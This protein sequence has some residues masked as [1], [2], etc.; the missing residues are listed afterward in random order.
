MS[1][2]WPTELRVSKDRQHLVV[3]FND[4]RSFDLS[5]EMLRVL[6]PSAEV[7][8]HGPGQKVTV[9]GKRNVAI[10]SLTPTG[11]YAVRIGFDDMHDTGIYTWTYLRELGEH[12]AE[13]FAAYEDELREKG[14]DRDTSEKPR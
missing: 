10:I 13:L 12:G 14:M 4:E 3:T 7:Q 2:I 6:S 11:N 5:A 8:G 9:P 1:D